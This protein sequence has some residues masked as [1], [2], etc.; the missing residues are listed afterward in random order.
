MTLKFRNR[1]TPP[2][3]S[4]QEWP[5]EAVL[6]ALERGSLRHWRRLLRVVEREPWGPTIRRVEQALAVS[7]PCGVAGLMGRAIHRA[8]ERVSG[9][10]RAENSRQV[11]R[12]LDRSGLSRSEFAQR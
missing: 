2:D 8:R 12:H 11:R 9:E 7:R 1:E 6:M 4:V 3:A 5:T 10:E